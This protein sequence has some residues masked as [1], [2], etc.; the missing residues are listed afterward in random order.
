MRL[1]DVFEFRSRVLPQRILT[2]AAGDGLLNVPVPNQA[3][4]L[5]KN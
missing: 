3:G 4:D 1:D 2:L 5:L